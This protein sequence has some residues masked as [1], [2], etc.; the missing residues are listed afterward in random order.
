[1]QAKVLALFAELQRE[2]GFSCLFI[3][4]DL[5]VVEEVADRVG[6]LKSGR[7]V[8]IGAAKDVLLAPQVA[9]TRMLIESVPVPDPALQR[10][11]RLAK[12]VPR[13]VIRHDRVFG[14]PLGRICLGARGRA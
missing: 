9:Y 12:A 4:H 1:M 6:V 14:C 10:Q 2:L 11:R 3:S 5:A 13:Q 8:E 7:L